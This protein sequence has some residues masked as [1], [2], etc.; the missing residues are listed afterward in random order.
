MKQEVYTHG[1]QIVKKISY[2]DLKNGTNTISIAK[3]PNGSRA[4]VNV[5]VNE[6]FDNSNK[7]SVGVSTKIDTLIKDLDITAITGKNST[8]VFEINETSQELIATINDTATAGALNI[9]VD[10]MLPTIEE[11]DY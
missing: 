11:V 10:F 2:S 4:K 6:A 9:T 8:I 3:L 1:R 5:T 7:I